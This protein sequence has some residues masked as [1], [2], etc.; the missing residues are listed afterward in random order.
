M[1]GVATIVIE[2]VKS[3]HWEIGGKPLT[4]EGA[5]HYTPTLREHLG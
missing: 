2:E 5:R 4:T 3:G 1:R